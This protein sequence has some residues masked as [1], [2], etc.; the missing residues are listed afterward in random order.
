MA[1]ELTNRQLLTITHILASPTLEEA[2]K[3]AR[4]SKG[5]LYAWLK[6]EKFKTELNRQRDEI[7]KEALNRLKCALTKAIGGLIE[8]M[9]TPKEHLRRWVYKDIIEYSLKNIELQEL[10]ERL[11]KIERILMRKDRTL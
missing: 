11:G 3:K 8:L 1:A 7:A 10:E 6:D 4:V 5:T 2:R 9:D